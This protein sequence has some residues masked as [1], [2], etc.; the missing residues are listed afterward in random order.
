M[1]FIQSLY[2]KLRLHRWDLAIILPEDFGKDLGVSHAHFVFNPYKNK[3][4]ADPFIL[5]IDKDT[6]EVLVEEFDKKLKRGRIARLSISKR[7]YSIL[8]MKVILD[9][10]THL[11]FP[12]IRR[13][14]NDIF[15]YPENS[16]SG[17][18]SLYRY[19]YTKDEIKFSGT[20][21]YNPLTDAI[22][23]D[24]DG[25]HLIF[26]T[27]LPTPNGNILKVYSSIDGTMPYNF[28][29]DII[30]DSNI[31]RNGGDFFDYYGLP[32]RPAQICIGGYGMGLSLQTLEYDEKRYSF[33][34]LKRILPPKGYTGLHTY[35]QYQGYGI[36][37]CRCYVHQNLLSLLHRIKHLI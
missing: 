13:M 9:L 25:S 37:D 31:A 27:E 30:F 18:L 19:D 12:A 33:R 7:T 11:S 6:I 22:M 1:R 29:Y 2:K 4:F 28:S 24:K 23:Y 14:G 36:I 17:S 34:E 15:I 32:S 5:Y 26:A 16:A 8:S 10:E 20:L 3:W 21:V 35:N